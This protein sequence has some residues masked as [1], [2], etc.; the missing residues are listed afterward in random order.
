MIDTH[1]H[2]YDEAFDEDFNE[3][4]AGALAA[5]VKQF[6]LPG[7][8][9]S[10]FERMDRCKQLLG[11]MGHIAW[12][13]HPTSVNQSWEEELQL[14][15]DRIS[16]KMPIAIGEIGLDCYWSKEFLNEQKEAFIRQMK[17]AHKLSLPVIIHIRDA[18][19]I[20]FECMEILKKENS[21]PAGVFHAFSGSIETY[22]RIKQYGDYKVGIGGVITYKKA[23]IAST[24][25]DIP[26][27]DILLE[28]DS[29][30][31]TPTPHRGKRN[32]PSYLIYIAEKIAEIKKCPVTSVQQITTQNAKK[33][34]NLI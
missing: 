10:V 30:W 33:L 9:S 27:E 23:S 8:D 1:T 14:V 34:F 32:E 13:L 7:I 2:L 11:S 19:D 15:N 20:L 17:L 28:T 22:H 21:L 3:V 25:A 26:L 18:H 4:L 12:G 31:L 5:G 29:P 16:D 24:L 6:I